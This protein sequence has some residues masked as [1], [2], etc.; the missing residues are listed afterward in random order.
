MEQTDSV[1]NKDYLLDCLVYLTKHYGDKKS[2]ESITAG[3]PYTEKGM[4]IGLFQ[5]AAVQC[6]FKTKLIER[7]VQDIPKEVL[8]SV[9]ILNDNRAVVLLSAR[10]DKLQVFDPKNGRKKTILAE[11]LAPDYT[12]HVLFVHP[13]NNKRKSERHWFWGVI[14]DNR[15]IYR[16]VLIAALFINLFGLVG[17]L[18]IMN[19]Y[20]RVIPN[21]AIETGWVLGIAA[22]VIFGFD[23]IMRTLRGYFVDIAGR[24]VDVIVGRRIYD[25]VMNMKLAHRPQSSG[26]F[27][28]MLREFETV[29]DF[30][31]SAT[32]T[33]LVDLPFSL[34]FIFVIYLLA[35]NIAL[36]LLAI[37]VA[38]IVFGAL[39]QIPL[40]SLIRDSMKM[41]EAKHGLLVETIHG[42]ETVK[43]MRADG[44]MRARYG[45]CVGAS[46]EIGQQSRFY[47]GMAANIA[48]FFQQSASII[49]VLFGMYMVMDGTLSMGALIATVIM[50]GRAITPVGQLTSL[51]TRFHNVRGSLKT[52]NVIMDAPVERPEG[53]SFLHR[54]DLKG[55]IQFDRVEFAYPNQDRKI[56]DG[57]S[58]DIQAG[59]TVGIIGRI[60]S[61]KSTITK[62]ISGLYEPTA[63][64]VYVDK[65]DYRQI[66]P[67]DLRRQIGYI[68]QDT[69]LFSG[70]VR[71]NIKAAVPQAS[72]EDVLN[73]AK[74][75]GVH[76]FISR[77]P[78]G[79]DAPVGERGDGLSGGQK[80]CI[81]LARALISNPKILLLDEPTNDMDIQSE[82]NFIK[83]LKEQAK[84]K[85]VILITHRQGLI[86]LVDRL[87][88]IDNGKVIADGPRDKVI[89]A[90]N[91]G[92]DS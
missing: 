1:E 25:Q 15:P 89:E 70:S 20:D 2:P 83:I 64:D 11:T 84:D 50:G 45:D 47:S 34:L 32:V 69:V 57:L 68:S 10:G 58:F 23:F 37:M 61:G 35:G 30:C 54:P 81:A 88:L 7:P 28:S 86:P 78:M 67:A 91:K 41:A 87:I 60:G 59:E 4:S 51:V 63:G 71:D 77:H 19:V 66:D 62:I 24:R 53:K 75:A 13:I 27:A 80:Q 3:L 79:Y 22:L 9:L 42:L 65:T 43:A 39:L 12:G 14:R 17:P 21:N 26:A 82:D 29:K 36:V 48:S 92:R 85:T 52:L 74:A 16:K 72:D 5:D 40:K 31:T 38:V 76:D 46:A 6:G 33:G 73:A 55:A 8:P 56:L 18:F 49:L 44:Q 90:L